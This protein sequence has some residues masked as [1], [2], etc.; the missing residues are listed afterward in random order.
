MCS[1]YPLMVS[2][3]PNGENSM[4]TIIL[5]SLIQI[6][7]YSAVFY[8]ILLLQLKIRD[9]NPGPSEY[10]SNAL[11]TELSWLD[12]L[13]FL[14]KLWFLPFRSFVDSVAW[15]LKKGKKHLAWFNIHTLLNNSNVFRKKLVV[16]AVF[17]LNIIILFITSKRTWEWQRIAQKL[18]KFSTKE[19]VQLF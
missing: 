6:Q 16:H 12:S 11:P 1:W 8:S 13:R 3:E 17:G 5:L 15:S 4:F 2:V 19:F 7:F 18:R 10:R 14:R 9:L